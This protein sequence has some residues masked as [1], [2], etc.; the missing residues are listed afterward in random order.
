MEVAAGPAGGAVLRADPPAR[1]T[2][3]HGIA[4]PALDLGGIA[5]GYG[6]DQAARV[7]REHGVFRGLVNVGGDLVALGDGPGGRPWR[8]GVR[9]PRNPD[10]FLETLELTEES[11]AT[12]GDYLRWFEHGGRRY[13]HILDGD[14]GMP[15]PSGIR[16]ITVV[17][18]DAMTADAAATLAFAR[19]GREVDAA[20]AGV[21]TAPRV[22]HRG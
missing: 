17:A 7:L 22:V 13:H 19:S 20:F 18:A 14:T 3:S 5:K 16:T 1:V 10:G 9:D 15:V 4:T 21:P 2:L 6:A 12:S 11:V 8:V